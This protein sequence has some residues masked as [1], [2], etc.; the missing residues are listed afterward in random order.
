MTRIEWALAERDAALALLEAGDP[1]AAGRQARAA[2]DTL[3]AAGAAA[4][5][6]ASVLTVLGEVQATL[7]DLAVA[8]ELVTRAAGLMRPAPPATEPDRLRLWCQ[9]QTRLAG[10]ERDTGDL[11]AAEPRL[12]EVIAVAT[13]GLGSD[14]HTVSSALNSL[15]IVYKYAARYPDAEAAY[16]RAL[17]LVDAAPEPDPLVL[18]DLCHNLG[19]LDHAR[20]RP[21]PGIAWAERGLVLREAAL[22]PDH[23]AVAADV[24]ALGALY[25]LAGRLDSAAVAYQRAL[26]IFEAHYGPDHYEVGMTCANL[27]VLAGDEDRPDEAVRLNERARTIL[28]RVL[29]PDHPEVALTLHNLGVALHNAGRSSEA[30]A[31]LTQALAVFAAALPA[32]HPQLAV[33]RAALAA[34]PPAARR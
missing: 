17:R 7:S 4:A 28:E 20:G 31:T 2:L 33:T 21:E 15:G 32:D 25:H 22:G 5:E 8:R 3:E 10:L 6:V 27:A 26:E 34:S 30:A 24:A 29:G 13:A 9:I 19:G 1:Q 18:A 11:T 14:D 23:S 16:T 12:L